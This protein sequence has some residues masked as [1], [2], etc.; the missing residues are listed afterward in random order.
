MIVIP[1][2]GLSS[3]FFKAGFE[4]PKYQLTV[5]D[6]YV[7][8]LALK[9]F[10]C[11]FESE[12]FVIVLRD[13]FDTKQFVEQRL[14]ALSIKHYLIKVLDFE[15]Q[16]QAETVLLGIKDSSINDDEPLF[17]FNIDTFRYD[18][19]KPDFINDCAGYLEVFRGDGEHWSFIEIDDNDRVSRTT[20]KQ[21]ISDLCS[22]GLYYFASKALYIDL[23][24]KAKAQNMLVNNELYIAPIYNLL[25]EQGKEVRY[26]C[27]NADEIDFCGTPDE[28][29][30]LLRKGLKTD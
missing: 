28:Y 13:C 10:G 15:T 1:M 17:I 27:I 25:I 26:H 19:K 20:E 16:G 24:V 6:E 23:I 30:S 2:A 3:R 21:R 5:D 29:N 7:F 12:L 9:S 4:V 8:D 18:F 22:D 11:Y 14:Q